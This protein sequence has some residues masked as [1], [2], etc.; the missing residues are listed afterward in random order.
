[1]LDHNPLDFR[2]V[3]N[4]IAGCIGDTARAG[5][6]IFVTFR[7]FEAISGEVGLVLSGLFCDLCIKGVRPPSESGSLSESELTCGSMGSALSATWLL[8]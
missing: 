7:I 5:C 1:M 4:V 3:K 2:W 8:S 6:L